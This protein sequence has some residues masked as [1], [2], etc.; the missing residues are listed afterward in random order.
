[1][2][3]ILAVMFTTWAVVKIRPGKN[4]GLYG[5]HSRLYPQ[6]KYMTF[7]TGYSYLL[8]SPKM[9]SACFSIYVISVSVFSVFNRSLKF[10]ILTISS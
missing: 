6:F 2:K 8:A 3:V 4:S 10:N 1:M 7:K 9:S 5:I